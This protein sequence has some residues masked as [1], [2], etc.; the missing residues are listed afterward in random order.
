MSI[1]VTC[2]EVEDTTTWVWSCC[3][4]VVLVV[5][6]ASSLVVS[7]VTTD[8]TVEEVAEVTMLGWLKF[9]FKMVFSL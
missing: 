3:V 6:V 2:S 7:V 5:P 4:V 1:S 9:S 8:V